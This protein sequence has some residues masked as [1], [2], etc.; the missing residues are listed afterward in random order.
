MTRELVPFTDLGSITREVRADVDAAIS[1]VVS[2]GAFIGGEQVERFEDQ[3]ARYCQ[4]ACAVSV[5]NGTDALTLAL[6]A[7]GIGRGD[8]VVVP[9]NTFVATAEAVVLAGATPRFADV[10][11]ETLLLTPAA[12]EAAIGPRTRA[13][14]VVHLYGQMADMDSLG[15]VAASAGLAVVEDAAQAHGATWRGRRAGSLGQVGCFSF[16]PAKNLGAFGDAGAVVTDDAALAA[17]VRCLRDHGRARGSH[18][19][20]EAV[21]TNSRMDAIQAAV[22]S[23][24]LQRLETWTRARRRIAASYRDR[25][26]GSAVRLVTEAAGSSGAYHLMVARV[27]ARD[28]VGARLANAGISTGVHYPIP[29]HRQEPYRRFGRGPLPVAERACSEVLSLPL[30]PHMA[31]EQVA[32][33]C[34]ELLHLVPARGRPDVA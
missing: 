11:P 34:D 28:Q 31:S 13:V 23:V 3:W 16:Y 4:T 5:G 17:T 12:L 8:E 2:S 25:L 30:H 14:I 21:G 20:H 15:S 7:L 19:L 29:C 32:R 9:A 1:R 22:L 6:R 10:D 24:K 33:V 27:P 26:A 18:Y